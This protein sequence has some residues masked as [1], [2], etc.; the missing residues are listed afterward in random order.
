MVSPKA[1][2]VAGLSALALAAS[3][4]S[5]DSESEAEKFP[6]SFEERYGSSENEATWYRHIT[7]TRMGDD[8][9]FIITT[10]LG[11][12]SRWNGEETSSNTSAVICGAA[13]KLALELGVLGDEIPGVN[14]KGRGGGGLISCA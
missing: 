11:P 7:A 14:V 13:S 6:A 10:D 3:G 8:G 1:I 9:V 12:E 5:G 2:A 4:C